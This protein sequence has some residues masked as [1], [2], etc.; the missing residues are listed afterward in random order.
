MLKG[1]CLCGG[2]KYEI[3]GEPIIIAHCHCIDC[4]KKSGAGHTTGAMFFEESFDVKGTPAKFNFVDSGGKATT[5]IFC[6]HCGSPLFGK[7]TKMPGVMTVSAGTLENPNLIKPQVTV[8]A[9]NRN[10]WDMMDGSLETYDDMP[11]WKPESGV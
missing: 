6:A 3:K 11:D 8:C 10:H 9:K 4:Q 1:S 5:H 7:N 2:V